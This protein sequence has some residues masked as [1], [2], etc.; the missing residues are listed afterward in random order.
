MIAGDGVGA[1]EA[2]DDPAGTEGV[3]ALGVEKVLERVT[4]EVAPVGFAQDHSLNEDLGRDLGIKRELGLFQERQAHQITHSFVILIPGELHITPAIIDMIRPGV[5]LS[6]LFYHSPVWF[7]ATFPPLLNWLHGMRSL[8]I[9]CSQHVG[10]PPVVGHLELVERCQLVKDPLLL[11]VIQFAAEERSVDFLKEKMPVH[12]V[13][14]LSLDS[15]LHKKN[16]S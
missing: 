4:G 9:R 2:V 7:P 15:L 16:W 14:G 6:I 10:T 12:D 11:A 1:V 5:D 13:E 3:V 8:V